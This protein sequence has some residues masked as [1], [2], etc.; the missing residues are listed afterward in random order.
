MP[1][2]SHLNTIKC[3]QAV[4][5]NLMRS[6]LAPCNATAAQQH[7]GKALNLTTRG[8]Q[9][10]GDNRNDNHLVVYSHMLCTRMLKVSC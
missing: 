5:W 6:Q 2:E 4:S 3:N 1:G 10:S 7:C 8:G 9:E